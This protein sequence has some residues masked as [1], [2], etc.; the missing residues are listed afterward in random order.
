MQRIYLIVFISMI[1]LFQAENQ[2]PEKIKDI[3][4][5]EIDIST[6][7]ENKTLVILTMKSPRCP[8]CRKQIKRL[9]DQLASLAICNVFFIVLAAGPEEQIR[10]AAKET[11]FPFPFV[12]DKNMNIA[13]EFDLII[14]K[15][16]IL[17]SLI[18]LNASL[19][20]DWIQKGR[21]EFYFGDPEL[22][23]RLKCEGWI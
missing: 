2:F 8:V 9:N 19:K 1:S 6:I 3:Y 13:K 11:H 16:E 23:K 18:I 12:E 7:A 14:G 22:M 5:N 20:L 15:N 4:N 10:Q 17:P 21:N